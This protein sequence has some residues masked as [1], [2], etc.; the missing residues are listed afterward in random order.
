[1]YTKQSRLFFCEL[2]H[3]LNTT[4]FD[5]AQSSDALALLFVILALGVYY[6]LDR[7]RYYEEAQ[8]YFHL[9]RTAV[10]FI[11]QTTRL[12]IEALVS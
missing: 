12:F 7:E 6:D 1:M 5:A 2:L 11:S 3:S 10:G 9:A 4:S 8:E